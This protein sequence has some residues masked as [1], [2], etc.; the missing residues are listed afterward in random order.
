M[1]VNHIIWCLTHGKCFK[2]GAVITSPV[3]N[4][5][6]YIVADIC[7]PV[8]L[9]SIQASFLYVECPLSYEA[10]LISHSTHGQWQRLLP[11]AIS[12]LTARACGLIQI[13]SR[14]HTKSILVRMVVMDTSRLLGGAAAIF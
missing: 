1:H 5:S 6:E 10:G 7:Y 4:P 11:N 13:R 14:A 12:N 3:S 2:V 8:G 9:P